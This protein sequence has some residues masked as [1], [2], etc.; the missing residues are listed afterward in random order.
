MVKAIK[1]DNNYS[2]IIKYLVLDEEKKKCIVIK[3]SKRDSNNPSASMEEFLAYLKELL[4]DS[5]E[6]VVLEELS[7]ENE[8]KLLWPHLAEVIQEK[9]P[10][11]NGFL[12]RARLQVKANR[13]LIEVETEMAYKYL[14]DEKI[15][16]FIAK[17]LGGLLQEELVL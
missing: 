14:N 3:N 1:I 2:R 11:I 5:Y 10:Y 6:L 7:L 13:V 4:D 16:D 9:Y 8:I 15:R 12:E 17:E